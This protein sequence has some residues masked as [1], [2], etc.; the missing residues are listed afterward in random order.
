MRENGGEPSFANVAFSL[1]MWFDI[2]PR[3][4]CFVKSSSSMSHSL[5]SA[6]MEDWAEHSFFRLL[7]Q[8]GVDQ[9]RFVGVGYN[10]SDKIALLGARVAELP[11]FITYRI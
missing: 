4:F 10:S 1:L 8:I 3:C 6:K 5:A 7:Y 9:M 2:F 11:R